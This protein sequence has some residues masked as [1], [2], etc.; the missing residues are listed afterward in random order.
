MEHSK[1]SQLFG[2]LKF[3]I[4]IINILSKSHCF[5]FLAI[6]TAMA[7]F[8][9]LFI[10]RARLFTY[11]AAALSTWISNLYAKFV[12]HRK[13]KIDKRRNQNEIWQI[14]IKSLFRIQSRSWQLI[15]LFCRYKI[16]W[17]NTKNLNMYYYVC[18]YFLTPLMPLRN[19]VKKHMMSIHF[20]LIPHK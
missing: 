13:H 15:Y 20:I 7:S 11:L 9:N 2:K 6:A 5:V 4:I 19:Q 18:Y 12:R 14:C 8:A 1:H 10:I 3:I 17:V 16:N